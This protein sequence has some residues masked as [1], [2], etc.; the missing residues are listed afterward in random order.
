MTR[1]YHNF[2]L[3]IIPIEEMYIKCKE[4]IRKSWGGICSQDSWMRW[5]DETGQF[6]KHMPQNKFK[7]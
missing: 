4:N 6:L 5:R 1:G 2:E 7:I 3:I